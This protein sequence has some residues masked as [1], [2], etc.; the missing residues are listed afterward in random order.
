VRKTVRLILVIV[1]I[2][3]IVGSV[4]WF[5]TPY[6]F[7]VTVEAYGINPVPKNDQWYYFL[8]YLGGYGLRKGDLL[9][10]EIIDR[11]T[12]A[13]SLWYNYIILE[14]NTQSGSEWLDIRE[15]TSTQTVFVA[16]YDGYFHVEFY[17]IDS[18]NYDY[19]NSVGIWRFK[20]SFPHTCFQYILP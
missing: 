11:P 3:V 15:I 17:C 2:I 5:M 19:R 20:I 10:F 12:K 13:D 7:D 6:E 4:W 8:N 1:I 9:I 14:Q 16:P 18:P